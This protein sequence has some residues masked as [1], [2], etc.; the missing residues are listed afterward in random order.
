MYSEDLGMTE[1]EYIKLWF[2]IESDSARNLKA[3]E[4]TRE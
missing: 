3:E 2:E 1:E 4:E